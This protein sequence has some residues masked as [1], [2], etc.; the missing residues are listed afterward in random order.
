M[1]KV[2]GCCRDEKPTSEFR[3]DSTRKDGL[4]SSCRTC[5]VSADAT[6]RKAHT[7]KIKTTS[8]ARYKAN[9]ERAK[10]YASAYR[11]AH[12][13]ASTGHM[14]AWRKANPEKA[15]AAAA[16]YRKTNHDRVKASG[17]AWRTANPERNQTKSRRHRVRK[18][19]AAGSH[20]TEQWLALLATYGGYCAYCGH[21]AT[22]LTMDHWT[23]LYRGGS[24]DIDNILPACKLCN[25]SKGTKIGPERT[26]WLRGVWESRRRH[27]HLI[28]TT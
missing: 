24:D 21:A 11:K 7:E 10:S 28:I 25:S 14:A 23:P 22:T 17:I 12:P 26:A 2:C 1:G 20:T 15:K 13:G 18:L 5:R 8:A 19:G 9:P 16:A 6:Y 27:H 3:R 4:S